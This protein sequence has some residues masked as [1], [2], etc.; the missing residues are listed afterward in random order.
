AEKLQ[1]II[2]SSNLNVTCEE[3]AFHAVKQWYEYDASGR[4]QKLPD[5]I[6]SLRLTLFDTKF[7]LRNVQTLPG[8]EP[9]AFKAISWIS[10]PSDRAMIS[11]K[12]T[13]PRRSI[14]KM[15]AETTLLAVQAYDL[16]GTIFQYNQT[17]DEWQKY[18]QVEH[19]AAAYGMVVM[20]D[21]IIYIGGARNGEIINGVKSW[22]LKNEKV[23][24]IAFND[25]VKT[26]A[27]CCTIKWKCIRDWWR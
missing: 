23:E 8:C 6:S 24:D 1:A 16:K 20:E 2:E 13:E 18:A 9:L 15:S 7:L 10:L 5:L 11:I 12:Y 19:D 14:C 4:Q 26:L 21:N 25:S 17:G 22:S 27:K 3:D